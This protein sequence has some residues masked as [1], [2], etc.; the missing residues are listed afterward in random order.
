[1]APRAVEAVLSAGFPNFR[2]VPADEG[3]FGW[4]GEHEVQLESVEF[5]RTNRL[6]TVAEDAAEMIQLF[7]PDEIVWWI[8]QGERAPT[9][10]YELGSLVAS[11]RARCESFA[12]FDRLLA[13]AQPIA[14]GV[15]SEGPLRRL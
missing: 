11:S 1:M 14:E 8:E 12:D 2:V 4:P 6:L 5:H 9:V 13:Q 7:T 15:L 10:T 3:V